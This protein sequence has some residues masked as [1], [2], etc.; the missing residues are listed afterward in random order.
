MRYE[1]CVFENKLIHVNMTRDPKW[2]VRVKSNCQATPQ[3]NIHYLRDFCYFDFFLL[4]INYKNILLI[5]ID[6]KIFTFTQH[7]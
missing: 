6:N 2:M 7:N 3:N 4:S 1:K 5:V